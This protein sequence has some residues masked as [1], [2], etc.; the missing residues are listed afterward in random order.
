[1]F[2]TLVALYVGYLIV[3]YYA[4]PKA[5]AMVSLFIGEL[6]GGSRSGSTIFIDVLN[7]FDLNTAIGAQLDILGKLRGAVRYF[8][9]L[10]IIK[11]YLALPSYANASSDVPNWLVGSTY[12]A[13]AWVTRPTTSEIYIS[14]IAD[15]NGHAL[16]AQVTDT[17]WEYIGNAAPSVGTYL[18][19]YTYTSTPQPS[20][21]FT[22]RY[23]DFLPHTM[24]DEDFRNV[25][26]FLTK[27]HSC[28]YA[29]ATLDAI[30][31]S[32]FGSNVDLVD[33]SNMSITYRHLTSDTTILYTAIKQLGL[34]PRPA[35]VSMTATEV[36]SF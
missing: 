36:A 27:V 15:N 24:S 9:E 18:G 11:T 4:K 26:K 19:L 12:A 29:Y 30:M 6:L 28:D 1:M 8:Y 22:M 21:Q 35:G 34:L 5:R 23:T 17:N 32:F 25:I 20:A 14:R 33:N 16:P 3:Q 7:G 2:D 10:N 13:G 31:F